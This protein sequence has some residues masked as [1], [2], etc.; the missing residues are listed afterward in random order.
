MNLIA[1][2]CLRHQKKTRP[3]HCWNFRK[4]SFPPKKTWVCLYSAGFSSFSIC[5]GHLMGI[6]FEKHHLQLPDG[7]WHSGSSSWPT[8]NFLLLG[9]GD[10]NKTRNRRVYTYWGWGWGFGYMEGST[11]TIRQKLVFNYFIYRILQSYAPND[12]DLGGKIC[13]IPAHLTSQGSK[14]HRGPPNPPGRRRCVAENREALEFF[15]QGQGFAIYI[16]IIIF[17]AYLSLS[18][19]FSTAFCDYIVAAWLEF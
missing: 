8:W 13:V 2:N 9:L 6:H 16:Y 15:G 18:I 4:S 11:I 17:W 1:F 12:W 3:S 19:F 14:W 5:S 10:R 7:A